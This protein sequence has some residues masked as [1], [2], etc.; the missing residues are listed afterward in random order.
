M[1]DDES[2]SMDQDETADEADDDDFKKLCGELRKTLEEIISKL[3][4]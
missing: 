1:P 2:K 4:A 3:E